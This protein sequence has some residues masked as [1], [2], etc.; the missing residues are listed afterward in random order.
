MSSLNLGQNRLV[1]GVAGPAPHPYR[2]ALLG[3]GQ[4][5]DDLRQVVAV[6]FRV[7]ITAE[8][9]VA[10]LLGVTL[11]VRAGGV[12]RQVDL[13]VEQVGDREEHLF[14]HLGLGVGLH[15][16]IHRSIRLVLVHRLQPVD[17]DILTGPLGG[18][19]LRHRLDR[20]VRT[21]ANSTR[22]MS[23][24]NRRGPTTL[25]SAVSISNALHSPSSR[26][27][28]PTGRD[29]ATRSPSPAS[30]AASTDGDVSAM[31]R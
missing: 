16:E 25:R 14:L 5:D 4:P 1:V 7:P 21:S 30:W 24:V 20:P 8:R 11:E 23:V 13:Q 12:E 6:V 2:D 18:R 10:G 3:D 29:P 26:C 17:R 27:T 28:T 19:Q 31:P 9:V 22:F 15:E